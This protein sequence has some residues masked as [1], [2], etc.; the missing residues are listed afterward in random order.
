MPSGAPMP[1]PISVI[2]SEP[3]MAL[4]NPPVLEPGGG[5]ISVNTCALRPVRPFQNRVNRISAS[6]VTPNS[7]APT[8]STRM[9]MSKRL[10]R[11]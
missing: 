3:T 8:Q 11:A 4:S 9:T 10:R 1:T 6:Q 5:V 2:S 7:A